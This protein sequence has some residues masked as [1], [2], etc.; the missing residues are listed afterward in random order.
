MSTLTELRRI[1]G[2]GFG[3]VWHCTRDGKAYAKKKLL[4]HIDQDGVSR[5]LR[6]VRILSKLDH[7]NVVK[8]IEVQLQAKPYWYLMPIYRNSLADEL[9]SLIQNEQRIRKVF[10]SI[11]DGIEY[12]HK[13]G[14]IHRDLKPAN[15]LL[16]SDNDL[17]ITDFGLGRM[18]DSES[19]RQTHTGYGMGTFFYMAPE[20][21]SAAKNADQRS[22][23]F[24][25]GR[26]LYELYSEPLSSAFQDLA[27]VPPGIGLLIAR[28]THQQP[29]RRYQSISELKQTW[30]ALTGG[31]LGVSASE[32]IAQLTNELSTSWPVD[33]A[34]V[35]RVFE[36]LLQHQS[37]NDLLHEAIMQLPAKAI[38]HMALLNLEFSRTLVRKFV[39]HATSQ[40]WGFSYTDRIG[41]VCQA[42]F[43]NVPDYEI[44]AELIFCVMDVG[45]GHNRYFVMD[46]FKEMM[47]C[48]KEPGEG[49][50]VFERLR[51]V[52]RSLLDQAGNHLSI[53]HLDNMIRQL[54]PNE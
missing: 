23:I 7:P 17:V 11:L 33:P 3:E 15:V 20:Q 41:K 44:R 39:E 46:I 32:E 9:P 47:E 2:G 1:G 16:N 30:L 50:A 12:A 51:G 14:V 48:R 36:L 26:M 31:T 35:E 19:T 18:L 21:C 27:Q 45:F 13:E 54:F 4:P 52:P 10:G 34:K 40:H 28:C 6:E 53:A 29:G 22:D 25:L 37:D 49:L 42:I 43:D 38:S 5:F 8:V 24:A